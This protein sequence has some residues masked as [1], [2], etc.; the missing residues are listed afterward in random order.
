MIITNVDLLNRSREIHIGK[1]VGIFDSV[2]DINTRIFFT[3]I[4]RE[5]Y[6]NPEVGRKYIETD[7]FRADYVKTYRGYFN[8]IDLQIIF[9]VIE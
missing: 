8:E 9:A 5:I 1:V 2:D 4:S 7:Q 6:T 3:Q